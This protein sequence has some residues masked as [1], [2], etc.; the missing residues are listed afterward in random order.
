M[1]IEALEGTPDDYGEETIASSYF[2]QPALRIEAVDFP[3]EK[4]LCSVAGVTEDNPFTK[5]VHLRLEKFIFNPFVQGALS[6]KCQ[7]L[8]KISVAP[9]GVQVSL[10]QTIRAKNSCLFRI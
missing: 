9:F 10:K 1:T 7:S 8:F 6:N 5:H 4:R 3:L 2:L